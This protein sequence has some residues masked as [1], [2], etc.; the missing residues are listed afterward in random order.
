VLRS[1]RDLAT[2]PMCT[3][4]NDTEAAS[5][6]PARTSGVERR[7]GDPCT[8]RDVA[9]AFEVHRAAVLRFLLSRTHDPDRAADLTQDVFVDAVRALPHLQRR[10]DSL[11][12]WLM[13]VARRRLID[14]VRRRAGEPVWRSLDQVPVPEQGQCDDCTAYVELL[15][16]VRDLPRGQRTV[17]VR[18]L[19][20]GESFEE[21]AAAGGMHAAACR[22]QFSRARKA[23]RR[24]EAD[25]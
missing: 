5:V 19:F 2:P 23:L 10:R 9:A 18:H 22:M 15:G 3:G 12:P 20:N 11:L 16:L 8:S 6:H 1:H 17:L 7:R 14:D 25:S 24:L 13:T 4:L 21:I